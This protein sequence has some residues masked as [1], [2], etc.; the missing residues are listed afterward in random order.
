LA[1]ALRDNGRVRIVGSRTFGKGSVQTVLPLDNGD[2]VKLT[3]A[4]YF[5]PSGKSIQATGIVP[6]IM[7]KPD[8]PADKD[9]PASLADYSEA[10][11]PG[12]LHGD[13]EGGEGYTAGDVLNGDKPVD[14]ALAELKHPGSVAA[15]L[16][17][18]ADKAAA[19]K[20][21]ADKAKP[22]AKPTA[23]VQAAPVPAKPAAAEPTA[24]ANNSAPKTDAVTPPGK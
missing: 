21:A 5:T 9:I 8:A 2:S 14:Q 17:A 19:D 23:P 12:H 4:R 24:P 15:A 16:K 1:G 22:A 18:A 11:L 13:Q 3:T 20:A 10:T 7:L 6:D